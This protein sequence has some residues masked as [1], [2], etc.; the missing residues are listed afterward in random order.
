VP[1]LRD[2]RLSVTVKPGTSS[3]SRLRLRGYGIEGGHQYLEFKI[4][5]PPTLDQRSRELME[6]FARLNPQNPRAG[7]PWA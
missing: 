5:V 2:E 4:M 7:L 6:E 3:G 1:T